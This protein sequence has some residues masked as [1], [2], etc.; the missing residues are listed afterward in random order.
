M[1]LFYMD[2]I[3]RT[4]FHSCIYVNKENLPICSWGEWMNLKIGGDPSNE[5]VDT[6]LRLWSLSLN[7][8]N[9]SINRH[10]LTVRFF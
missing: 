9:S 4:W 5:G 3:Y 6:T 10:L 8:F 1:L 2:S 7:G